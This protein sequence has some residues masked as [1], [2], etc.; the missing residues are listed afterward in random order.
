MNYNSA[1]KNQK[2]YIHNFKYQSVLILYNQTCST[3]NS[4]LYN[5]IDQVKY[6]Y[7]L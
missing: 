5:K 7:M 6:K 2:K 4:Y 3:N 1:H